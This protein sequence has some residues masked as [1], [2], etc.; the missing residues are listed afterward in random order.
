MLSEY[1]K[2]TGIADVKNFCLRNGRLLEIKK[3]EFFLKNGETF[4]FIGFIEEC[5]FCYL[6]YTSAG[7]FF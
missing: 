2:L 4:K 1:L 7:K 3:D 6:N 5:G